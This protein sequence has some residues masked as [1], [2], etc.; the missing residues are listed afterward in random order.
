MGTVAEPTALQRQAW[1]LAERLWK[2][3]P[4]DKTFGELLERSQPT[5]STSA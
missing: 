5:I 1:K 3:W 4:K 2:E